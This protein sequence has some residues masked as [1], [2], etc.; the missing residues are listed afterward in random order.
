MH[1]PNSPGSPMDGGGGAIGSSSP[2][3]SIPLDDSESVVTSSSPHSHIHPNTDHRVAS[4]HTLSPNHQTNSLLNSLRKRH[5]TDHQ[6]ILDEMQ[7]HLEMSRNALHNSSLGGASSSRRATRSSSLHQQG[8][9]SAPGITGAAVSG[10]SSATTTH[11]IPHLSS[12][13]NTLSVHF[14]TLF[15]VSFLTFVLGRYAMSI[16]W[17]LLFIMALWTI[18][19]KLQNMPLLRNFSLWSGLWL[20]WS[21]VSPFGGASKGLANG[22]QTRRNRA[23]SLSASHFHNFRR[24]RQPRRNLLD[25]S[26]YRYQ[27]TERAT[28]RPRPTWENENA[29]SALLDNSAATF[30]HPT[31][32]L[33]EATLPFN[34]VIAAL[35]S[36]WDNT[37]MQAFLNEFIT[38]S[39]EQFSTFIEQIEVTFV[40]MDTSPR[41]A[42]IIT[43]I[44]CIEATLDRT[45]FELDIEY[46]GDF[47]TEWFMR[48]KVLPL[49]LRCMVKEVIMEATLRLEIEYVRNGN[50]MGSF[51]E[52]NISFA[53]YP[54]VLEGSVQMFESLD[55]QS[56]AGSIPAVTGIVRRKFEEAISMFVYP[57]TYVLKEDPAKQSDRHK[58]DNLPLYF[59][60]ESRNISEMEDMGLEDEIKNTLLD[61]NNLLKTRL[62]QGSNTDSVKRE[63]TQSVL[64][65]LRYGTE[66]GRI[67]VSMMEMIKRGFQI[68]NRLAFDDQKQGEICVSVFEEIMKPENFEL[69]GEVARGGSLADELLNNIMKLKN[70]D[71][72]SRVNSTLHDLN[73]E[74]I[75][76]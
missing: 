3:S 66:P 2:R 49:N 63:V 13:Y 42:P 59:G 5:E 18:L 47:K 19:I 11:N 72:Q 31:P 75:V 74:D 68:L 71:F 23:P 37:S 14:S 58:R 17:Y 1:T 29:S 64:Q 9:G 73:M 46:C 45:V 28:Q 52:V 60:I 48:P 21:F 25:E 7:H 32:R 61:I 55:F 38:S 56:L 16:S 8:A 50:L 70:K 30:P 12:I 22:M 34:F 40:D 15:V 62:A 6:I 76:W 33:S 27:S 65:F 26:M 4:H 51:G 44:R 41:G 35:W 24:N 43:E 10:A 20:I 54:A 67:P 69:I 36:T 39:K 57:N 53:E